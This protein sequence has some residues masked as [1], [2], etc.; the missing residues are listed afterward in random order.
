MNSLLRTLLFLALL[1]AFSANAQLAKPGPTTTGPTSPE[2]DLRRISSVTITQDGTIIE[3]VYVAGHIDVRANN[4]TIR[5]FIIASN[6][7]YG[8]NFSFGHTGLTIED[9]EIFGM[10]SAGVYGGNFAARRLNIHDSGNDAF[11]A[12]GNALIEGN[13]MHRL[14]YLSN[15]HA[16]GIQINGGDNFIIRGNTFDMPSETDGFRNSIC[17]IIMTADASIDNLLIEQNWINGGGHS[18]QIRDKGRGHGTPTNVRVLDNRFGRDYQFS[19]W[20]IEGDALKV[21]NVWDDTGK[22]LDGQSSGL[23]PIAGKLRP[24][25]PTSLSV[26]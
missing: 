17:M 7:H 6:S 2:N 24:M 15:A 19:P 3:G 16:D 14:G 11:K 9:G 18:I 22:L 5:N 23:P 21:G 12:T 4:V 1:L 13:W 20:V 8:I 25:A 10:T 26:D